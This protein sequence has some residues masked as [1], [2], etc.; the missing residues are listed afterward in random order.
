M[1]DKVR[2]AILSTHEPPVALH[3]NKKMIAALES[4]V[5]ERSAHLPPMDTIMGVDIVQDATFEILRHPTGV[6]IQT[7][8]ALRGWVKA[9]R[10]TRQEWMIFGYESPVAMKSDGDW[11]AEEN[12]RPDGLVFITTNPKEL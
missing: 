10:S 9:E 5:L 11:I 4:Q 12:G 3:C 2:K 6:L 8:E 1:I 7:P